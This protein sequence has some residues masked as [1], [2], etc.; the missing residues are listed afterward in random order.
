MVIFRF[1]TILE[2][3]EIQ[4]LTSFSWVVFYFTITVQVLVFMMG[5]PA[6]HLSHVLCLLVDGGGPQHGALRGLLAHQQLQRSGLG[7][8]TEQL[9]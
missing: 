5:A 2:V 9:V 8:L 3:M 4:L 1:Y 6:D 7:Q